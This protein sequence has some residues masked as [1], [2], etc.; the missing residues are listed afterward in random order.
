LKTYST[1][2]RHDYK[3]GTVSLLGKRRRQALMFV[4]GLALPISGVALLYLGRAQP[5]QA[6]VLPTEVV[7]S[8]I[9]P[10]AVPAV[11]PEQTPP[12]SAA[13]ESSVPALARSSSC[14]SAEAT[15]SRHYSGATA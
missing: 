7:A 1:G 6:P 10:P 3:E 8:P 5:F 14:A 13:S 11:E 12:E 9:G 2:V 15:R 4:V